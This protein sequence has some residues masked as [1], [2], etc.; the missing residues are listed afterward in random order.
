MTDAVKTNACTH[1]HGGHDRHGHAHDAAHDP[2]CG[3]TVDPHTAKHRL[4]Y[5]GQDYFF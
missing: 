1:E 4:A 3:M 2:V 5:K